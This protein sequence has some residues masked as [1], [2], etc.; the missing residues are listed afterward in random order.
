MKRSHRFL[1]RLSVFC[2]AGILLQAG[3]CNVDTNELAAGL[4][5]SIV[6][7]FITSV[8]FGAFNLGTGV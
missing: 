6:N 8:V 2:S 1:R 5:T 4:L 7:T 3:A